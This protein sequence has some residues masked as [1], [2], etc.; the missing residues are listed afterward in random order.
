M[1]D[2]I[3][4]MGQ[5]S[6]NAVTED[7][8]VKRITAQVTEVDKPALSLHQIVKHGSTVVFSPSKSYIDNPGGQRLQMES[9]G[10]VY[11]LKMWVP[12]DHTQSFQGQ[13]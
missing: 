1:V 9:A 3:Q 4:H 11:M 2:T 6:F 12:K 8:Q 5:K 13:A 7:E 10:N